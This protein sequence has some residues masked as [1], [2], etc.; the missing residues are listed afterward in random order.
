MIIT[1][2]IGSLEVSVVGVGCNSF[3]KRVDARGALAVVDAALDA[4]VNFFDTADVYARGQSE[5]LL[6][7]A[8]G[9]RR[10]N[11][12]IATKFGMEFDPRHRGAR[13]S[14]VR[15]ACEHSL[16]RL[17]TDYIDLYQ[18]H[19]PDPTVP[20]A[21][22]LG[23][24]DDLVRQGKVRQIGCSNF[25]PQQLRD[26]RAAV[27]PGGAYFVSVQNEYSL[28]QRA[29]ED[30]VIPE[31]ERQGI[32]FLP[33]Y[34]L[35]HGLLTG[36]YRRGKPAPMGSRLSGGF[37]LQDLLNDHN[38]AVVEDLIRFAE[39][40]GHTILE[41][42]ISWLLAMRSVASVIAG[43]TRPEQVKENVASAAW[44]LNNAELDEIDR[45]VLQTH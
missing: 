11:V 40:R 19:E 22:T 5:Q 36:K 30:G 16:R 15:R 26:A 2:R 24:L 37:S 28:L 29:A 21:D 45:I 33:Y 32:A 6:G 34:P 25:T 1:R 27:R 44:R 3:G 35:A 13:P 42:A 18:L 38:L 43:A 31:C 39:S 41:L 17:G 7:R 8:L 20:I 9:N 12:I 14:Y 23:A 4:G 10:R